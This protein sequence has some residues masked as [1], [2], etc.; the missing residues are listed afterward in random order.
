MD[1]VASV[2]ADNGRTVVQFLVGRD[3][4]SFHGSG[5][6]PVSSSMGTG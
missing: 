1:L 4:F 2:F 3:F 5:I 6:Y